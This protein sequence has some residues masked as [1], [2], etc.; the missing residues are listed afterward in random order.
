MGD[1]KIV[2]LVFL[3]RLDLVI[4]MLTYVSHVRDRGSN[5]MEQPKAKA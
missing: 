5:N 1:K 2:T 4:E 3:T